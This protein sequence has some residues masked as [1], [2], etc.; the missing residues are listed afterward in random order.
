MLNYA[1]ICYVMLKRLCFS[2]NS[3]SPDFSK[4]KLFHEILCGFPW[5]PFLSHIA[6][7]FRQIKTSLRQIQDKLRQFKTNLRQN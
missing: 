7:G 5:E 4:P 2:M 3:P 6:P 1:K